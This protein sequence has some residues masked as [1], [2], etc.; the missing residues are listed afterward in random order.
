MDKWDAFMAL[1]SEELQDGQYVIAR[2]TFQWYESF[3]NAGFNEQQ[4]LVLT[5]EQMHQLLS[6]VSNSGG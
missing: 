6:T 2:L 5:I 1:E 4:A 3:L